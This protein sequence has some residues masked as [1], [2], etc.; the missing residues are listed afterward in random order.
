[1]LPDQL[2][3]ST[4]LSQALMMGVSQQSVDAAMTLLSWF[5]DMPTS[6]QVDQAVLANKVAILIE[7]ERPTPLELAEVAKRLGLATFAPSAGEIEC[8]LSKIRDEARF[9]SSQQRLRSMVAMLDRRGVRVMVPRAEV[10][11]LTADGWQLE[12]ERFKDR[13]ALDSGTVQARIQAL[14]PRRMP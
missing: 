9:V 5:D 8:C 6:R 11:S 13:S 2:A 12:S 4:N 3:D 10:Q 14:Q 1:M 7:R